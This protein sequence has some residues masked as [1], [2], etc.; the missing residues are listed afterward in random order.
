[1]FVMLRLY[2]A[3][4]FYYLIGESVAQEAVKGIRAVLF[5]FLLVNL[6]VFVVMDLHMNLT[7]TPFIYIISRL[8]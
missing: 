1:M 3:S 6:C 8:C 7:K 5:V 2:M 4:S